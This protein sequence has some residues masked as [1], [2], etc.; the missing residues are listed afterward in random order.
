MHALRL[1]L[2]ALPYDTIAVVSH[3]HVIREVCGLS[4]FP[5]FAELVEHA[6]VL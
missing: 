4:R 1:Y 5:G 2:R 3:A 6:L